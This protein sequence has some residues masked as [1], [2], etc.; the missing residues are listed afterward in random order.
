MGLSEVLVLAVVVVAYAMVSRRLA[1]TWVSGP[2]IFVAVGVLFGSDVL[3]LLD[4]GMGDG[5]VRVLAEATLVLL[6]YTDA[7]R[8]D[9]VNLRRERLIP[10]R[11]LLIGLPLTVVAGTLSRSL[12]T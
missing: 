11:L 2:M 7:I 1:T 12:V 3:G 6:L 9:L 5:P 10:M 8:I 4:F